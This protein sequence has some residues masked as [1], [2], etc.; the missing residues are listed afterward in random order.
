MTISG[1][2]LSRD[3][4]RG[5]NTPIATGNRMWQ[6]QVLRRMVENDI[7]PPYTYDEVGEWVGPEVA[8]KLDPELSYGLWW[9]GRH[10]VAVHAA[11]EPDGNGGKR[12]AKR[13]VRKPGGRARAGWPGGSGGT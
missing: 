10:E 6:R 5:K 4:S 1:N 3:D 13:E 8:A 7:Y 12:Y 11:S 2:G 9:Y